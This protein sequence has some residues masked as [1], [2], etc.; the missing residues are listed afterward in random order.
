ML[1]SLLLSLS[2][3][4]D[5]FSLFLSLSRLSSL[6]LLRLQL[7]I[8]SSR[9]GLYR[10]ASASP[11][12]RSPLLEHADL[13]LISPSP[14]RPSPRHHL[15]SESLHHYFLHLHGKD[16]RRKSYEETDTC[17]LGDISEDTRHEEDTDAEDR[18][19]GVEPA[20]RRT[21]LD[22]QPLLG[23]SSGA[24]SIKID[25][26]ATKD[27]LRLPPAY[28]EATWSFLPSGRRRSRQEAPYSHYRRGSEAHSRRSSEAHSRRGSEA[29][30]RRGSTL[31]YVL[32]QV[33]EG[34]GVP[35]VVAGETSKPPNQ[36][37]F[38]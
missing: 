19:R 22:H 26:E 20:A 37:I 32:Y 28:A 4:P 29:H 16:H 9:G 21:T 17:S 18:A 12:Q 11:I 3:V 7:Q 36:P 1:Y 15:H 33:S 35:S 31:S 10:P 14:P 27:T 23:R 6:R 25:C 13:Q 8:P 2:R 38:A 5:A 24:P 30:S 34:R